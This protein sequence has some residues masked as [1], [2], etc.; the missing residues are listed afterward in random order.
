MLDL[1]VNYGT[2]TDQL[3]SL[4]FISHKFIAGH[5]PVQFL[6]VS[7]PL[8]SYSSLLGFLTPHMAEVRVHFDPF[9]DV[10]MPRAVVTHMV[11]NQPMLWV[12]MTAQRSFDLV[13]SIN[14]DRLL[15]MPTFCFAGTYPHVL[16][17]RFKLFLAKSFFCSL[18][19]HIW[20]QLLVVVHEIS[21]FCCLNP[22]LLHSKIDLRQVPYHVEQS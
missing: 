21:A 13:L 18:N 8:C 6:L 5:R 15:N 22:F 4:S 17:A 20:L 11:T 19:S 14:Q 9:G 3:H 2:G 1:F 16:L 10:D 12:S 7:I